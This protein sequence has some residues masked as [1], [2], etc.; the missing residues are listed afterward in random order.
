MSIIKA[1]KHQ[2]QG[3][4]LD[5]LRLCGNIAEAARIA[6]CNRRSHYDWLRQ[7]PTYADRFQDAEEEATDVLEMEVR[8]RAVDCV[9]EPVIYQGKVSYVQRK[10]VDPETGEEKWIPTD[11][12]LTVKKKSDTLL[13]FLLKARDPQ[14][15]RDNY[16][17]R[18][19]ATKR[20]DGQTRSRVKI[21]F[22]KLSIE[23]INQLEEI[24]KYA[25][26]AGAVEQVDQ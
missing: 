24:A 4:F 10:V 6:G 20:A 5:A 22:A 9:E 23:Q 26:E 18:V 3:A 16:G 21:N 11:E 8:R 7:D 25:Q 2:R 14:K 13:M 15:Y 1:E 17:G 19:E 12:P